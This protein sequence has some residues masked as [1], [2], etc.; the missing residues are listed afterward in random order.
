MAVVEVRGGFK[1]AP[2]Y[3]GRRPEVA[4]GG[5]APQA[6]N[7]WPS[8]ERRGG[9]A[10]VLK[11]RD[12]GEQGSRNPVPFGWLLT[13]G[14]QSRPVAAACCGGEWALLALALCALPSCSACCC[15]CCC[16]C[17]C[18]YFTCCTCCNCSNSFCWWAAS[19]SA[20]LAFFCFFC[21]C[22]CF[23]PPSHSKPGQTTGTPWRQEKESAGG[24]AD[25][26][27]AQRVQSRFRS[28]RRSICR[29]KSRQP[30]GHFEGSKA[31]NG[32]Y[33]QQVDGRCDQ[34]QRI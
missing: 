23:S 16:C 10:T 29:E 20:S 31:N 21:R 30:R 11:L 22:P 9:A 24:I 19:C 17:C 28:F 1:T 32:R 25:L 5:P 8:C 34:Q 3:F 2:R 13:Y 4:C 14:A 33:R 6:L 7:F 26:S 15:C 18:T 27:A 12:R